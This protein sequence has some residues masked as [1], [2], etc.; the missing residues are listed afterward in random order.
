MSIRGTNH[1]SA[2]WRKRAEHYNE[3]EWANHQLYLDEF[4][5]MAKL[6]KTD[7]VLD[8]GTGTGIVAHAVAPFVK[9][10]IGLD[11]SQAMLEHSNW[12]G[13]MYFVRRNIL[14]PFFRD[15]VFDKVT[16]RQV[17]HHILRGTQ[18]AMN[19]CYRVLKE[20]GLMVLSEGIPPSPEVKQDYIEIFKLKERRLTFMEDDLI[21]LMERAGFKNIEVNIIRLERM[22][23][24]NWLVNS[25]LP[26]SVQDEIFGLHVNAKDYF[27]RAYNMVET[28]GDCLIDMKMAILTGQKEYH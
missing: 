11:K 8:V 23:V 12:Y 10:V 1:G 18:Q 27:K 6:R 7:I 26:Q 5:K 28:D 4:I 3:L 16:A 17:F 14:N 22:S 2:F 24:R 15:E 21:A 25:G 20:G 19:Q 13:N 9:Q